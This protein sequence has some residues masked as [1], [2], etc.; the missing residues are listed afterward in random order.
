MNQNL[1]KKKT[2]FVILFGVVM[3][4]VL[5]INAFSTMSSIPETDN[6]T[7][8]VEIRAIPPHPV[9]A[10]EPIALEQFGNKFASFDEAKL[11]VGMTKAVLPSYVPTGIQLDSIR[12]QVNEA[13]NEITA[14]YV[15]QNTIS[16]IEKSGHIPTYENVIADGMTINIKANAGPSSD[17]ESIVDFR[18]KEAPDVRSSTTIGNVKAVLIKGTPEYGWPSQ[19][20]IVYDDQYIM[21]SS[22]KHDT[23]ELEKVLRSMI[24]R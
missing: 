12:T 17:W 23:V 1:V 21:L 20:R 10:S 9:P 15:P 6:G 24:E 11:S 5:G 16:A 4:A 22:L 19:V 3:V 14:I 18:V 7:P 13:G 8:N 2:T